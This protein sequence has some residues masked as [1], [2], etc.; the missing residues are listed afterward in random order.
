MGA[1]IAVASTAGVSS[2]AG[3]F[4]S[5]ASSSGVAASV[6]PIAPPAPPRPPPGPNR[7][8]GVTVA[9][10]TGP[11]TGPADHA[12]AVDWSKEPS[13]VPVSAPSPSGPLSR[14]RYCGLRASSSS[15]VPRSLTLPW[16]ITATRSASCRVERRCAMRMVVRPAMTSRSVAWIASSVVASTA[17]VAS[18]SRRM[19]GSLRIARASAMR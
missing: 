15:W 5:F 6:M 11:S 18:S 9:V 8:M 16:S 17:E 19:R 12:S 7:A 13:S 14:A 2:A 1:A 10:A 3:S 4:S